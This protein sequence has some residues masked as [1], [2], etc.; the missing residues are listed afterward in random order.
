MLLCLYAWVYELTYV[1]QKYSTRPLSLINY[2]IAFVD[3]ISR[4]ENNN[5]MKISTT[6]AACV[7]FSCVLF[8]LKSERMTGYFGA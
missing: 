1:E 4:R 3:H 5:N 7:Y 2:N 6:N 8:L